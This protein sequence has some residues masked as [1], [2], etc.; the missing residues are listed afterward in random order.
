MYA[1]LLFSL[2]ISETP[3]ARPELPDMVLPNPMR[4]TPASRSPPV[5]RRTTIGASSPHVHPSSLSIR[6]LPTIM[7]A[8]HTTTTSNGTSSADDVV[9]EKS[10]KGASPPLPPTPSSHRKQFSI[11]TNFIHNLT[12]PS[13]PSIA[14]PATTSPN[15]LPSQSPRLA[16]PAS[17]N[18]VASNP[19]LAPASPNLRSGSP[20]ANNNYNSNHHS[21][22]CSHSST[23]ISLI[24]T[25]SLT[26]II[27][28]GNG[29][30]SP[31]MNSVEARRV[32]ENSG[33][34]APPFSPRRSK[35]DLEK[36]LFDTLGVSSSPSHSHSSLSSLSTPPSLTPLSSSCSCCAR[37]MKLIFFEDS[38]VS[39]DAPDKLYVDFKLIGTG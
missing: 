27:G 6:P 29:F 30:L 39:S 28:N 5:S 24:T 32:L 31:H 10:E 16:V 34:S 12:P 33:E 36:D 21:H 1:D 18:L 35:R 9:T 26:I 23:H 15:N 4:G 11:S 2:H 37:V 22:T 8:P 3:R 25:Q 19:H 38:S 13:S 17:P 20:T 7:E 14:L